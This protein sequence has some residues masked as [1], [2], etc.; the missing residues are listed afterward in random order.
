MQNKR[1][2]ILNEIDLPPFTSFI[3]VILLVIFCLYFT[4]IIHKVPINKDFFSIL[5]SN[6][7]HLDFD[8]LIANLVSLYA[9]SRIEKRMGLQKFS[10]LI[11]SLLFLNTLFETLLHRY[12]PINNSVGFSGILFGLTT[13]ELVLQKKVDTALLVSLVLLLLPSLKYENVSFTG[14]AVGVI[15]GLTIALFYKNVLSNQNSIR[16]RKE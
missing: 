7:I 10:Y 4:K 12:F 2:I 15:S 5:G 6:F 8:H 13:W 11:L 3:A 1:K 9:L 14:H 16:K